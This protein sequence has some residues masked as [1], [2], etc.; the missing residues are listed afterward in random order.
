MTLELFIAKVPIDVKV[1]AVLVMLV[2]ISTVAMALNPINAPAAT[3]PTAPTPVFTIP[4]VFISPATSGPYPAC[5]FT[6]SRSDD[7][8]SAI[9]SAAFDLLL[10]L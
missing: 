1:S 5:V 6:L 3:A 9:L 7:S 4:A 2:G 8:F 10:L